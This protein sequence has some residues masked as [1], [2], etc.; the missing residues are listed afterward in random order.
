MSVYYGTE[1]QSGD[2][3]SPQQY[4]LSEYPAS[5]Y[6]VRLQYATNLDVVTGG[7]GII[8]GVV[9]VSGD[10]ILLSGQT[11]ESENGIWRIQIGSW[12]LVS[13]ITSTTFVDLG[14]RAFDLVDGDLTREIV[15]DRSSVDFNLPGFY[16]INYY[17][18]NSLG[19][20]T[21]VKRKVTV[22]ECGVPVGPPVP[23]PEP[24][25]TTCPAAFPHYGALYGP[26]TDVL[27]IPEDRRNEGYASITPTGGL[28]ITRYCVDG[29]VS[30]DLFRDYINN[31][32]TELT[33]PGDPAISLMVGNGIPASGTVAFIN[34]Q[35]M[36][37]HQ[38]IDLAPGSAIGDSVSIGQLGLLVREVESI[39]KIITAG[40]AIDPF[41]MVYIGADG[42]LY[43]G[44]NEDLT[45]MGRVIGMS[46]IGGDIGDPVTVVLR[47]IVDL[48]GTASPG[49]LYTFD[50]LGDPTTT[51]PIAGYI[52]IIGVGISTS[53]LFI[54]IGIPVELPN[55]GGFGELP[56]GTGVFGG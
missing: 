23:P 9:M 27:P 7:E 34:D 1:G 42:F 29:E 36:G 18:V 48:P 56:F 21:S 47:G 52:Q 28:N 19:T 55:A 20:L 11:D 49:V 35:S 51:D 31:M 6:Y 54:Q 45:T 33:C 38:L 17:L 15:T 32:T 46:I 4:C 22:L 43:T 30:L 2:F 16:T 3:G 13:S 12:A 41:V 8:S 10:L 37:C 25:P 44:D 24:E 50:A 40:E 26:I 5:Y 14:A 39:Q 53:E